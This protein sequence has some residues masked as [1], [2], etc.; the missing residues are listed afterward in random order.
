MMD[1]TYELRQRDY[2]LEITRAMTSRLDLPSLLQLI[3]D[4]AAEML[5]AQAALI[6]VRQKDSTFRVQASYGVSTGAI[7][8]FAPLLR[9]IPI[10]GHRAQVAGWQIP[11]LQARLR[12]VSREAGIPLRHIVALPMVLEDQLTGVIYIFRMTSVAFS[13]GDIGVL[14]TFADQAAIAVHNAS[15]YQEVLADKQ[16]LDA[17]IQNSADGIMILGSDCRVEV[18]N[19]ALA[20]MTGVS[21]GEAIGQPCARVLQ[22][23]GA[24]GED[25]CGRHCAM[26]DAYGG[27]DGAAEPAGGHPFYLEGDFERPDGSRV[28]VGLTH[29]LLFD[30]DG[31]LQNMIVDVHDITR[32]REA[33]E[34]QSTF[35]SIISHELK[36]PVALIK[37]YAD[38]LMREDAEWDR[39]TVREGLAI[40]EEESDRLEALID[41]LLDASRIQAGALKLE[42]SDL[43]LPRLVE[44]VV[45]KFRTQTHVHQFEVNFPMDFPLVYADEERVSQVLYNLLAN[46]IKYSPKG[47]TIRVGGW[48]GKED[49]VVYV[50]DQG[51]GIPEDQ[52]EHVFERFYRVDSGLRRRTQGAGL[53]LYL[54][55]SIVEAS[56][57]RIW[58][59]SKEG[60]GTTMYFSMPRLAD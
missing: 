37:G 46:A 52:Q 17:L 41:N 35:I 51:I 8:L 39:S 2:L 15:L 58:M 53:G 50:A 3:L 42:P 22:L 31:R 44:R 12:R 11:D 21:A 33:E 20:H 43:A 7:P 54:S 14:Q 4:S 5:G 18:F 10:V 47:G 60:H 28:S 49:A 26:V 1:Y 38:T 48:A 9:D 55:R 23:K 36:T 13:A 29:S 57:G 56:G 45:E 32:F 6:A 27:L 30:A 19:K 34:L 59:E 25:L 40:I 24:Q 16:R